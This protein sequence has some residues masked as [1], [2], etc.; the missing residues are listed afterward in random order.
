MSNTSTKAY[1]EGRYLSGGNSGA[2]SYRHMA[3]YKA[4]FLNRFVARNNI[5]TVAELGC[6]DGEQL[7]RAIYPSYTGYDIAQAAVD[8]CGTKFAGDATKSFHCLSDLKTL[9]PAELSMS[10]DVV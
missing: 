6:G 7:R 5:A 3:L 10:L 8:L 1:W 2:G 4:G 9:A